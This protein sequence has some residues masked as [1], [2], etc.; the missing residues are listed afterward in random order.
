MGADDI[1]GGVFQTDRAGEAV[2]EP[3]VA[4]DQGD[5][6]GQ[7]PPAVQHERRGQG[8]LPRAGITGHDE[9][10]AVSFQDGAM[11]HEVVVGVARNAPIHAP[12]QH[13]EGL[14]PGQWLERG[15][16]V[17]PELGL[18]VIEPAHPAQCVDAHVEVRE[19]PFRQR[20]FTVE[21]GQTMSY[22]RQMTGNAKNKRTG[23][24]L[25]P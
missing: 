13:G 4:I 25:Q 15:V 3:I 11:E 18:G 7:Q 16:A 14:V 24:E 23:C 6:V 19:S 8:A 17:M 5:F 20:K 10:M 12:L 22:I 1:D 9:G 21:L 2:Q